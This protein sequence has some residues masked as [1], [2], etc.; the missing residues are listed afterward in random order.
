MDKADKK[1]NTGKAKQQIAFGFGKK[2]IRISELIILCI[3]GVLI[4]LL[5]GWAATKTGIP[6]YLDTIG[7]VLTA[8]FGG[9]L[10]AVLVGLCSN[11]LKTLFDATSIYYAFLNVL[12]AIV[13]AVMV[14]EGWLKKWYKAFATAF[15]LAL[16]GGVAGSILTWFLYGFASGGVTTPLALYL[17]ETAGLPR[18]PAQLLADFSIDLLDK[19]ATILLACLL[20]MIVPKKYRE[21]LLFDGWQQ[22]PLNKE[23]MKAVRKMDSRVM[24]LRTKILLLLVIAPLCIAILATVISYMLYRESSIEE[25]KQLASGV[26]NMAAGVIDPDLVDE[27]LIYGDEMEEYRKTE[28]LLYDVRGSSPDIE[29]IYVY[30]IKKDGCHVVFDL[31]TGDLPGELPGAVV[32][33]DESFGPYLEDLL[34][35]RPI[36]PIITDDTYGWLLTVYQPVYDDAGNC[37]CYAAADVSMNRLRENSYTFFAKLIALFLGFFV[38]MLAF[39]MWLAEYNII[40]PVN[41]MAYSASAFAFNTEEAREHGVERIRAL[42]IHTGD[43]IENLYHAFS[44]TTQDSMQYVEDIQTQSE[45]ITKMQNGLILVLADMV[46]SRDQNTGDHVRKTAAYTQIIMDGLKK[47]GYYLD[48]LTDEFIYDVYHSSPLHDVGKIQVSDVIL[49]KP[50]RLTEEEF[51]IMKTHTTAG[52]DVIQQ[53]IEIVPESGYLMEARNLAEFHHEKW[54]GSGYPHGL[55]ADNIPLSARIMAVADVFDALVSRRSYKEPFTFEK[56]MTIISDGAGNHFDPLVV[57]VFVAAAD[58]VRKV[59]EDFE[60]GEKPVKA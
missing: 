22:K 10:P 16:I 3:V 45:T 41:S 19:V 26:A 24:S 37:V 7:T 1:E 25:H 9:Y 18:F 8:V 35:G 40:M 57:K 43:E 11:L 30:E 4:N 58:E 44:K 54:D 49:N 12:M 21:T 59:A 32:P 15:V 46:E 53:A 52:R 56:A 39:G 23:T 29:Y 34:A 13:V 47:E 14:R 6:L 38:L 27:F 60:S 36:E 17:N 28:E 2:G 33:F 31:D 51:E 55:S 48:Q 5:G 42:D 50:G 20:F